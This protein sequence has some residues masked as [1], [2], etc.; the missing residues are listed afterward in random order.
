M[1]ADT[2]M[3]RAVILFISILLA[4]QLLVTVESVELSNDRPKYGA[5]RTRQSAFVGP[6]LGLGGAFVQRKS[7]YPASERGWGDTAPVA[8]GVDG[9][10]CVQYGHKV[11]ALKSQ[12]YR[13]SVLWSFDG[14]ASLA[15]ALSVSSDGTVFAMTHKS[16]FALNGSTGVL[17]WNFT[18]ATEY[19]SQTAL[20][21][22]A[23]VVYRVFDQLQDGAKQLVALDA[24]T[25][26][27]RWNITAYSFGSLAVASDDDLIISTR[28][29]VFRLSESNGQM[30]WNVS[31]PNASFHKYPAGLG[32]DGTVFVIT[33][34]GSSHLHALDPLTGAVNWNLTL[35]FGPI[36]SV[37]VADDGNTI[38]FGT[39]YHGFYAVNGSTGAIKWTARTPCSQPP[40]PHIDADSP[41][42]YN[43]QVDAEGT[44]YFSCLDKK[45]YALNGSTGSFIGA[46]SFG[47]DPR[48]FT[49]ANDTIYV[50]A[51]GKYEYQLR[52][53]LLSLS[54]CPERYFCH[55]TGSPKW[56]HEGSFCPR[57]SRWPVPCPA[58]TFNNGGGAADISACVP[59]TLGSNCP[60]GSTGERGC[61][62]GF[63]CPFLEREPYACPPGT[64]RN[65]YD[66]RYATD[67]MDCKPCPEGAGCPSGSSEPQP[68]NLYQIAK[69]DGCR[70]RCFCVS[71]WVMIPVLVGLSA[72]VLTALC[73]HHT[74]AP[75]RFAW[76]LF[77]LI[78]WGSLVFN[79][80][81]VSQSL[82]RSK[83]LQNFSI[84]FLVLQVLPALYLFRPAM[85][86]FAWHPLYETRSRAVHALLRVLWIVIGVPMGFCVT[87]LIYASKLSSS[88][89]IAGS[90]WALWNKNLLSGVEN[91]GVNVTLFHY[92]IVVQL[93]V[94]TL[95]LLII[96]LLNNGSSWNT[97]AFISCCFGVLMVLC[98]LWRYTVSILRR[99]PASQIPLVLWSIPKIS[100]RISL[101]VPSSDEAQ[102]F[103]PGPALTEM[104]T[105]T[106]EKLWDE[107]SKQ[108]YYSNRKTG[109][110]RWDRPENAQIF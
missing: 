58:G 107:Q 74:R 48:S 90:W 54:T 50:Q 41:V 33:A 44:I 17:R 77:V 94:E 73:F 65:G 46:V 71:G 40:H 67:Y 83:L 106:W 108:Y 2:T 84:A 32:A 43:L 63:I 66:S 10:I 23:R 7:T 39:G 55:L 81:Y 35:R 28:S 99:T 75:A 91:A 47:A 80:L 62:P 70:D 68:C 26:T 85:S 103:A 57:G 52:I 34:G 19:S 95:P 93:F 51:E 20:T 9:S 59:C 110:S 56:C 76:I 3:R 69:P 53:E 86:S 101:P 13:S 60:A 97:T 12:L 79:V 25:G 36:M 88:K 22:G 96:Q 29:S 45:V 105:E 37:V 100:V 87:L 21:V 14:G 109:E 18:A 5:A 61:P 8:I 38:F 11:Y 24:V 104:E 6:K 31:I 72:L 82:F 78:A 102:P 30:R 16:V 42:Y 92:G 15:S 27:V 89:A 49:L 98:H 1:N 64:Y 4:P